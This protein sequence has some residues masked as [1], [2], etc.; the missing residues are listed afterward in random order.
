MSDGAMMASIRRITGKTPDPQIFHP[1]IPVKRRRSDVLGEHLGGMSG[2]E[3]RRLFKMGLPCWFVKHYLAGCS[4]CRR[5][6]G[7]HLLRELRWRR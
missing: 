3:V 2:L 7:P 5:R 6:A 4:D 1:R